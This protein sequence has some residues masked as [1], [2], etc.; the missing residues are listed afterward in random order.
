MDMTLDSYLEVSI[1]SATGV[2]FVI[3]LCLTLALG[4][5][6]IIRSSRSPILGYPDRRMSWRRSPGYP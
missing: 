1:L 2:I 4:C 3:I 5:S 6:R